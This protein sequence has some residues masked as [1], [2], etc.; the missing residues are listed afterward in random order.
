LSC[1]GGPGEP[2]DG[3]LQDAWNRTRPCRGV[4]CSCLGWSW[5]ES[6]RYVAVMRA[7]PAADHRSP[8]VCVHTSAMWMG[9][10]VGSVWATLD[11]VV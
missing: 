9:A 5:R 10:R 3:E 8:R 11:W 4:P 7:A 6:R 1:G 2:G